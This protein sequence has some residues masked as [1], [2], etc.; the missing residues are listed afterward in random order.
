MSATQPSH[1][2]RIRAAAPSI[3]RRLPAGSGMTPAQELRALVDELDELD[4]LAGPIGWDRYGE[5]GAVEQVERQVAELLGKPAAAMFPSGIMAQ[6]AV[7]RAWADRQGSKRV[8]LP[9]L[10]HL[11]HH[12]LDGPAVLH[13]LQYEW[14]TPGATVPTVDDLAAI[15]GRLGAVLLELPLRDAGY[16]LPTWDELVALSMAC[17]E[18]AVPLH[19]D[20]ARLWESTPHLGHGLAEVAALADSVYV[21]FYKGLGGLAGAAVAGSEDVVSEARQWR[22]RHGGT[23]FTMMPYAAAALRGLHRELPRMAD[24]HQRALDLA[25]RLQDTAIRPFPSMPHT[26]AFR[27]YVEAAPED[28]NERIVAAMER[29]HHPVVLTNGWTLADVPGWSWTELTVG[30]PTL[31]WEVDEA[32]HELVRVLLP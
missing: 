19:F 2:E 25:V 29:A 18:R 7:L 14:L 24:Y 1:A 31:D 12:E 32:V 5:R 26:N 3:E 23:L 16:Q 22:K 27:L 9:G 4:A 21:S 6:Q 20:G 10:S 8:A 11:L 13:G 30:A 15:P 17:R 28:L